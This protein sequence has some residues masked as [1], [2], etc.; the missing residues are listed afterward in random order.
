MPRTIGVCALMALKSDPA[1]PLFD[2]EFTINP[3]QQDTLSIFL[4]DSILY[5]KN[6]LESLSDWMER[7]R[8][9]TIDSP[10]IVELVIE[11]L[12]MATESV[13]SLVDLMDSLSAAVSEGLIDAVSVHGVYLRQVCLG[14]EELPF[15]STT[16]LWEEL[17]HQL[18][19]IS[20]QKQQPKK[21]NHQEDEADH[22]NN[23][24]RSDP[25]KHIEHHRWP[26]S[27]QQVEDVLQEICHTLDDTESS[28]ERTELEIRSMLERVPEASAAYFL[29]FL[30]CLKHKDRTALDA[31]H[32]FFDLAMIQKKK[33][34]QQQQSSSS[35]NNNGSRDILQFS[36][37]LLA[38]VH[39]SFGASSAALMATEEAV[40]VAQQSKDTTCAAF[41]LG[42]LFEIK[43]VVDMASRRELLRRCSTRASQQ[44]IR[45]LIMGSS[46]SLSLDYLRDPERDPTTIWRHHIEAMAEPSADSL[47][48]WDRPT[49]LSTSLK[50]TMNGMARHTLVE[51]GIWNAL[52]SPGLS[53][54]ASLTVLNCHTKKS[55]S[56]QDRHAA[57]INVAQQ[58]QYGSPTSIV[59]FGQEQ[60]EKV[61]N[62]LD[63][64]QVLTEARK[65][66]DVAGKSSEESFLPVVILQCHRQCIDRR[67]LEQAKVLEMMMYSILP[68][69]DDSRKSSLGID[70]GIQICLRLCR[71][72]DYSKARDL[73]RDLLDTPDLELS[74]RVR[75]LI[76]AADIEL[77]STNF[78]YVTALP[79]L[80]EAISLCEQS[81][82]HGLHCIALLLLSRVF[83]KNRNPK[84]A[85]SILQAAMP[86]IMIRSSITNQAEAYLIQAKCYMQCATVVVKG[87]GSN[88]DS[89]GPKSKKTMQFYY[90]REALTSLQSSERLFQQSKN[91]Y[92][93]TEVYY[94]QAQL[95]NLQGRF[96]ECEVA[97]KRFL[98]FQGRT[99]KEERPTFLLTALDEII[100]PTAMM[101]S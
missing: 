54:L 32:Q 65:I 24:N 38:L 42:K 35:N 85:L 79:H 1:S 93:L 11:T 62:R 59:L 9:S 36:A 44:Q 63:L 47:P 49:F 26:L 70:M 74:H 68:P 88:H 16:F 2:V 39:H 33:L 61:D 13:D 84:R 3:H 69:H 27:T 18:N 10:E 8:Q 17:C 67:D 7:L 25:T 40:R 81:S 53:S 43:G 99:T 80:L 60:E 86:D 71:S 66:H 95:W 64:H 15:E 96:D 73:V 58:S 21:Q 55:S 4:E 14:F 28:F 22:D 51:A 6:I 72:Q 37:I 57:L 91:V 83:L 12:N 75:L 77:N 78:Q 31:L 76:A 56:V 48:H 97:S 34:Q 19:Q 87:G 101:V 52:G 50:E 5:P 20:Q 41:A 94:L 82:M 46:L 45:Q 23:E 90:Y 89:S 29:R 92:H 100:I 30:N 98:E